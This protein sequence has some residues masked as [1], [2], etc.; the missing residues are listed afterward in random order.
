M[1]WV[2][3]PELP[4]AVMFASKFLLLTLAVPVVLMVPN[5]FA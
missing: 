5:D 1:A 3:P 4:V 2:A